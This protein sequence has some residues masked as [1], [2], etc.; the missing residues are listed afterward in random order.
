[1][2]TNQCDCE[3]CVS[4]NLVHPAFTSNISAPVVKPPLTHSLTH[5]AHQLE[6]LFADVFWLQIDS[7]VTFLMEVSSKPGHAI[8]MAAEEEGAGIIVMGTRGMGKI[9]RTILGSVSDYVVHHA[10]CPTA[11]V[12]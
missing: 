2:A 3:L 11:I 1:M 4:V 5:L 10:K 8:V 6:T 12:R 9:C 7:H